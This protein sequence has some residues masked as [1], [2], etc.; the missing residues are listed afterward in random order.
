MNEST[1]TEG[2][3]VHEL[4]KVA[5]SLGITGAGLMKR[6]VLVAAIEA[7]STTPAPKA[8]QPS[9]NAV[10]KALGTALGGK[11]DVKVVTPPAVKPRVASPK[12][13][14]VEPV[15]E[16]SAPTPAEAAAAE[17]EGFSP[18]A[19]REEFAALKAWRDG[20]EKGKRPST[21][22]YDWLKMVEAAGGAT[23]VRKARKTRSGGGG[24]RGTARG[25]GPVGTEAA[26]AKRTIKK[27]GAGTKVDDVALV[28]Y[29][30]GLVKRDPS[31]T[32]YDAHLACYWLAGYSVSR[33]RTRS[34]WEAQVVKATKAA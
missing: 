28:D 13:V 7:A 5:S 9:T 34:L 6:V 21:P 3:T 2:K 18:K 16:A 14:D 10:A 26:E 25:R 30:K 11:V 23:A 22:N 33:E 4:R 8:A 17:P 19:A 29:M 32:E 27:R 1:I 12:P 20:G 15:V 24:T 31:C